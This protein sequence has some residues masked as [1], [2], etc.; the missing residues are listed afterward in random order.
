MHY[1]F[2]LFQRLIYYVEWLV[3]DWLINLELN[4]CYILLYFVK[5]IV[6]EFG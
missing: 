6:V 1:E 2:V 4:V 5:K 3:P